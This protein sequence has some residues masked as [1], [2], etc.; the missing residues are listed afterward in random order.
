MLEVLR[1]VLWAL[2]VLGLGAAALRV[3]TRLV[4]T[5]PARAIATAVLAV[6]AAIVQ[7][8]VL[9]L[10]GLGANPAALG[11]AA[12]ATWL[13]ARATLPAPDVRPGAEVARWWRSLP[14]PARAG[15]AAG[16]GL[17]GTLVVWMLR[18]P[19]IGF[20]SAV[21]HYPLVAG[22]IDNGRPG[23]VLDLS[24]DIPYGSYPL[25]DEVALTWG[26]GIARSWV[27]IALWN[28]ALGVLLV[29]AAW[30]CLRALRVAPVPAGL[31]TAAIATTPIVVTQLSQA[32]TD[33]PA[34]TWLA[35]V[36]ALTACA[37]AARRPALLAPAV[38]AAGLAVGTKPSTAPVVLAVLG[39]GAY[40]DR[41]RLRALAVPLAAAAAAA[42]V[43]GGLWY[44]R[45]LVQHGSPLWPFVDAPWGDPSPR[46][47]SL[48]S[49][50]LLQHPVE[51]LDGRLHEY[52]SRFA[53]ALLL[54]FAAPVVALAGALGRSLPRPQRRA[55]VLAGGLSVAAWLIWSMA[56]GT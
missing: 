45:N 23:S 22:W 50:T 19:A 39:A 16:A 18:W 38:V 52:T 29:L 37:S 17:Y 49:R 44:L 47:L 32:Q 40:G 36:A 27:P 30:T 41:A 5:G 13:A 9:G 48:P 53:G 1:H 34:F 2:A 10:V 12:G 33:L 28:P 14:W 11:A 31:A 7:A 8:L 55:M 26:A 42:V 21:Y 46:F 43:V 6:A 56:W 20:D 24:Y 3:A 35:C 25:T 54:A 15:A 4:P 51:T